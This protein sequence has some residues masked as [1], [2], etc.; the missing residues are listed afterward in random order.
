MTKTTQQLIDTFEKTGVNQ[1]PQCE[2]QNTALVVCFEH[3]CKVIFHCDPNRHQQLIS[4]VKDG[5]TPIGFIKVVKKGEEI[6]FLSKPLME[7]K[8]DPKVH[9][10]LKELSHSIGKQLALGSHLT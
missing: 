2:D 9:T 5:G 3:E 1:D 4:M 6:E 7:F 8:D 10:V